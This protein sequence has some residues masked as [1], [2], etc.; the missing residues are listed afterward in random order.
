M[1][2][3][4]KKPSLAAGIFRLGAEREL[5]AVLAR[6]LIVA[7]QVVGRLRH[8]VGAEQALDLGVGKA[9]AE[10]RIE[11]LEVL[12]EGLLGLAD[13]ERRPR[14]ALDAAGDADVGL[15]AGD[16]VRGRGERVE[17]RS[18][19]TIVHRAGSLDRQ[20]R[21]QQRVAGDIAAVLAGLGGAAD[22]HVVD[23]LRSE[24]R[25]R[26]HLLDDAAS[27]SSGRTAKGAGVPAERCAQSVIDVGFE[28]GLA[29]PSSN[30]LEIRA[31]RR[32]R[33]SARR[34]RRFV[35]LGAAQGEH[36][37]GHDRDGDLLRARGADVDADRRVDALDSSS[38]KPA[39]AR[40]CVRLAWLR[41]DPSA[42]T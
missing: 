12:A 39:S 26:H 34:V 33:A 40:R 31:L 10:G 18:A 17:P 32:G 13:H 37:L 20:A 38:L 8:G 15:A 29:L 22:R 1:I 11:H 7:R 42:P 5:V 25:A 36:Q 2:S 6:E 24:A 3:P 27:R 28:H 35:H 4:L 9:R 41:R 30:D 16:G 14:H 19:Q 21:Q 23:R